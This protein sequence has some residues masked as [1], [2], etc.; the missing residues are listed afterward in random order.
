MWAKPGQQVW[1]SQQLF[2]QIYAQ[3]WTNTVGKGFKKQLWKVHM[4]F[5]SP[6]VLKW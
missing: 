2:T 4:D 1:P 6:L 3:T 5:P